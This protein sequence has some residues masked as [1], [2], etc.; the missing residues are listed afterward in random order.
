M[1]QVTL[2]DF[3]MNSG[4]YIKELPLVLTRYNKVVAVIVSKAQAKIWLKDK[5]QLHEE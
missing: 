5:V 1:K 4:K 2:R 3:Q